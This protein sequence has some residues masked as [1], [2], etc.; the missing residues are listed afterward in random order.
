MLNLAVVEPVAAL[1]PG[2]AR[3]VEVVGNILAGDVPTLLV[4]MESVLGERRSVALPGSA[5]QPCGSSGIGALSLGSWEIRRPLSKIIFLNQ[6]FLLLGQITF[7]RSYAGYR[8]QPS[9]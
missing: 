7:S 5:F 8:R 2:N 3:S 1:F 6:A 9:C 4:Q